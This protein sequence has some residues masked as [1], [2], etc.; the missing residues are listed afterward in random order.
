M[1]DYTKYIPAYRTIYG[2]GVGFAFDTWGDT[3]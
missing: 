3:P 1:T 2:T